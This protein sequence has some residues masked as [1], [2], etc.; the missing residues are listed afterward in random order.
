MAGVATSFACKRALARAGAAVTCKS[1]HAGNRRAEPKHDANS[2]GTTGVA[3][4]N[5]AATT[6]TAILRRMPLQNRVTPFGDIV[7]IPQ[8][9]SFTGNRGIIHEPATRTLTKSWAG[10]AWIVCL[11]AFKGA[12]RVPMGRR[13]WT[14]L[15]FLDEATAFAAGH[16]P[17]FYC[18]RGAAKAFQSAWAAAR[19]ATLP[20]APE[21]DAVL[22]AERLDGKRKRVHAIDER[23]DR[24]PDGAMIAV[25]GAAC[26]VAG[27]RA[28]PWREEGYG[29]AMTITRATTLITP[30]STLAVL[31]QGYRP[32]LHDS[33]NR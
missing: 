23:L 15:F 12:R 7:A 25:D 30:P 5:A 22:H 17:C 6:S 1:P 9:G 10:R 33:L 24:L 13:S 4:P 8:R 16:R 32:H 14:E 20:G 19:G 18:R 11:L 2:T 26:V 21:M 31:R 29:P 27:G 28:F 3:G